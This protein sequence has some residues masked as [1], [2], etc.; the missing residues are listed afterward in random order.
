MRTRANA[1]LDQGLHP[2]GLEHEL[3]GLGG[4]PLPDG[5]RLRGEGADSRELIH[6]VAELVED[7]LLGAG[8]LV[9]L[10]QIDVLQPHVRR[11]PHPS[12]AGGALAD[13]GNRDR[14]VPGQFIHAVAR[15]F[16]G[17]PLLGADVDA[18]VRPVLE[19]R[20]LRRKVG[21][22]PDDEGDACHDDGRAQPP[23]VEESGQGDLVAPVQGHEEGLGHPVEPAVLAV[24]PE[25]EPAHHGRER[26]G[27]EGADQD[28]PR[29]HHAELAEQASGE[30]FEEHD[31]HEHR[32]QGDGGGDDR[33]VDLARALD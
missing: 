13:L 9:G 4:A 23:P 8:A 24:G 12:P 6:L 25:H 22:H 30:P 10:L 19:G 1:D 28:R 21:A 7:L 16:V 29:H 11:G 27:H 15:V 26:E 2:R 33:E 20:Q 17:G 18:D 5:G 14:D 3:D 32:G 31:G